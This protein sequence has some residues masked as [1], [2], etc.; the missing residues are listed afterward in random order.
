[1]RVTRRDALRLS[2]AAASA[3]LLPSIGIAQPGGRSHGLAVIGDLKYPPDFPHFDYVDPTAPRGGRLVTTL[4]SWNYNQNP[5]TFNTLN[6][7]VLQGDGA[8]GIPFTFAALMARAT[9][10]PGSVYGLV[11]REV[12]VSDDRLELRFFL[13]PE[14]S[15][16]DGAPLT[17]A[18]VAFSL[19]TLRDH[20]HPGIA[21]ELLDI[22]EIAV[23]DAQTIRVRL[24]PGSARSLPVTVASVP[25]FSRAWWEGRDFAAS[26]SVAPLGSGPYRVAAF[27]FGSYIEFERVEDWWGDPLPVVVGRFNFERLRYEYFRDRVAAFEAFKSGLVTFREEFTSRIWARDYN[28]PALT[29]QRVVRDELPDGAPSG[30]Q[31][32][33]LNMRREKFADPRIRRALALAFDFEWT[34]RNLMFD[35]YE[36]TESFFENSPLKAEGLPGPDELAILEPLRDVLPEAVFGEAPHPPVSDASGSDRALLQE[37]SALLADAGCASGP[38]GLLTPAGQP[39]TVEFLDYDTVFEPHHNAFIGNLRLLGINATYRVVDPAQYNERKSNYDYDVTTSRYRLPLYPDDAYNQLFHSARAAQPGSYNLAGIAS[40][41]IDA[42]L[43][44][45]V[46]AHDWDRFVAACRALDRAIRAEHFFIPH[47]FKPT[48]WV[49]YWDMFDRPAIKPAYDRAVLDTWWYVPEKA[50]AIGMAG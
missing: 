5:L 10:E 1:M 41:G 39:F 35:S 8:A 30:A 20:G 31:G 15:F 49:A 25:I 29:E 16:H 42:L 47:W 34:N 3:T 6:P 19:E 22:E 45:V 48:H 28:F 23:E 18:D 50:A 44:I 9:D 12:E 24:R 4:D 21:T 7:Y 46:A 33:F 14:A 32:W 43:A 13:R 11:A 27:A 38:S 26:L 36:R 40:P 2:V 17:A 37:A